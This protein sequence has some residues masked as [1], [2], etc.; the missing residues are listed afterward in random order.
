M[1]LR[2]CIGQCITYSIEAGG[3]GRVRVKSSSNEG[4]GRSLALRESWS[5]CVIRLESFGMREFEDIACIEQVVG[6]SMRVGFCESESGV[7]QVKYMQ[8]AHLAGD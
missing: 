7:A 8:Y 2:S 3:E 5:C 6:G 4:S 1:Q